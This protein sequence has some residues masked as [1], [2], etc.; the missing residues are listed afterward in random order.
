MDT[1]RLESLR[2]SDVIGRFADDEDVLPFDAVRIVEADPG[3][4]TKA[5]VTQKITV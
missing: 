2:A 4:G 3:I 1:T 5:I